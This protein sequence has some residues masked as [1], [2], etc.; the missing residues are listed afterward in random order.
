[1]AII[2]TIAVTLLKFHFHNKIEVFLPKFH[3]CDKIVVFSLKS[4]CELKN[5]LG[6]RIPRST[7]IS[8][9]SANT[10]P[11]SIE[12]SEKM[13]TPA[14]KPHKKSIIMDLLLMFGIEKICL[15]WLKNK[16]LLKKICN[17]WVACR[18][19]SNV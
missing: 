18:F 13:K 17:H 7:I 14:T 8:T 15:L 10:Q 11:V 6:T 4:F 12:D 1:M 16:K 9:S 5:F 2:F 3:F 19:N